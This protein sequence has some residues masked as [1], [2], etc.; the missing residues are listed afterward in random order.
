MES[1]NGTIF[2][3]RVVYGAGRLLLST[4]SLGFVVTC[5]RLMKG[6]DF[7]LGVTDVRDG[8]LLYD[9]IVLI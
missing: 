1:L 5:M 6:V 4:C 3:F 7:A 8:K 9:I 2:C